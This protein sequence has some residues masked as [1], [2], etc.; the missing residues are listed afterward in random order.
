LNLGYVSAPVQTALRE[1]PA[2]PEKTARFTRR[3]VTIAKAGKLCGRAGSGELIGQWKDGS[4]ADG[5]TPA[6]RVPARGMAKLHAA[7]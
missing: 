7:K 6:V 1:F 5:V 3:G 2:S 4:F